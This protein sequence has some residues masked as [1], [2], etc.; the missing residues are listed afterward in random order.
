MDSGFLEFCKTDAQRRIIQA[1]IDHGSARQA[2]KHLNVDY[3]Y[4]KKTASLVKKRAAAQGYAPAHDMIHTAPKGFSVKG[5]S[6][7]YHPE[8]GIVAQW[9]KTNQNQEEIYEQLVDGIKDAFTDFKGASHFVKQPDEV[10]ED[11]LTAYVMGDP[12]FGMLAHGEETDNDDF[13]SEIARQ[14]M[15]GAMDQL[16]GAAKPTKEALLVNV[17][18]ALHV[19]DSTNKTKGR[20]NPLDADSRYYKII[21]VFCEAMIHSVYRMLE[22]HEHVTVIN[23]SGNHDI[24]STHWIQLALDYYFHDEPRVTVRI[25]PSAYNWFRW[26]NNLIGVTH[27]DGAKMHDLPLLMASVQKKSW[28]ETDHHYWWTGHIHHKQ[29]QEYNGC[30][31]ESF[32]T[33]APSDAWHSR[34]GYFAAREMHALTLHKKHGVVGRSICP[35]GLALE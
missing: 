3:S 29:V 17:G 16:V 33:L 15:D 22:K 12:H 27:G 28:G 2:A 11:Y 21:R 8:K 35:V 9:V 26:E 32:N 18:D 4:T 14:C 19:D 30:K 34:S 1:I 5:T 10:I 31:V 23:Q 7:L 25:N 20:G 6:T 24:D 13:N